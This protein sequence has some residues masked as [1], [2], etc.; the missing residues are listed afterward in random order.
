[1][2]DNPSTTNPSV[3]LVQ[4]LRDIGAVSANWLAVPENKVRK[5]CREAADEIER[6][7]EAL[8]RVHQISQCDVTKTRGDLCDDLDAIFGISRAA[9]TKPEGE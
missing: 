5:T 3:L 8:R 4:R 7:R 2:A 9:L 1:M 6:L